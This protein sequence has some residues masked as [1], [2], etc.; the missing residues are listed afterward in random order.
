MT[1][2]SFVCPDEDG[3]EHKY[4]TT[5]FKPSEGVTFAKMLLGAVSPVVAKVFQELI[6]NGGHAG[7]AIALGKAVLDPANDPQGVDLLEGDVDMASI[8]L[9]AQD[10]IRSIPDET[11][12]ALLKNT[13]RDGK[14]LSLD[15]YFN[16]AY[17]ANYAELFLAVWEVV[18]ANRFLSLQAI[19][20]I[21]AQKMPA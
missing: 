7:Q 2:V 21:I 11:A 12:R 3:V 10:A 13:T 1:V 5:L 16:E 9:A 20:R 17:I 19:L 4:E 6:R 8:V 14:P 15:Q 18:M